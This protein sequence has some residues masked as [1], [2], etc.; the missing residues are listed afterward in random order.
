MNELIRLLRWLRAYVLAMAALF[1]TIVVVAILL[2]IIGITL[3]L[4]GCQSYDVTEYYE[5]KGENLYTK[6][7]DPK[8]YGPVKSETKRSGYR[9]SEL[10]K[11]PSLN[12]SAF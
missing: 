10:G 9:E 1:W 12:V 7:D 5:P 2:V 8:I 6:G 3:L 11:N 4:T